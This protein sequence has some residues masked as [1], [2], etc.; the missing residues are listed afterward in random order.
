L[1]G[2]ATTIL[3]AVGDITVNAKDEMGHYL[4]GY[5]G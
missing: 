5:F 1:R 4:S 3:D 2:A